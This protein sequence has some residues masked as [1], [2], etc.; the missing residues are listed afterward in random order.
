MLRGVR[1]EFERTLIGHAG[2]LAITQIAQELRTGRVIQVIVI[3]HMGVERQEFCPTSCLNEEC[4]PTADC[5]LT[6]DDTVASVRCDG[7]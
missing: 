7:A 4:H 1:R 6:E 3:E 2:V 5:C